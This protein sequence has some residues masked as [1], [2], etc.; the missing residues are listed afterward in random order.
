MKHRYKIYEVGSDGSRHDTNKI[1]IINPD[2]DNVVRTVLSTYNFDSTYD[3]YYTRHNINVSDFEIRYRYP[4][5][6]KPTWFL[7]RSI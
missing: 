4:E 7:K 1:I 3:T 6:V 5:G 2:T